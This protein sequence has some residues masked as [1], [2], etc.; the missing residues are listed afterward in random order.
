[1]VFRVAFCLYYR[2]VSVFE[3]FYKELLQYLPAVKAENCLLRCRH[4]V[5]FCGRNCEGDGRRE[6]TRRPARAI[7][8]LAA[9]VV[10]V[11]WGKMSKVV[12]RNLKLVVAVTTDQQVNLA[13]G[14]SCLTNSSGFLATPQN[15]FT[16]TSRGSSTVIIAIQLSMAINL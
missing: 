7:D 16:T 8:I 10:F 15:T 5:R 3:A 4:C 9:I 14:R 12:T 1:M 13:I 6:E 11:W 2:T